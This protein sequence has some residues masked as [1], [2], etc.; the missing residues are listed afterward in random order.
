MIYESNDFGVGG[1]VN[2]TNHHSESDNCLLIIYI[3]MNLV[4][5]AVF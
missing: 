2:F 3:Q 1:N 4:Y 5:E